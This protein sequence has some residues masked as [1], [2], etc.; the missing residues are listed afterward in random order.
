MGL[1][2]DCCGTCGS[3]LYDHSGIFG[4][5]YLCKCSASPYFDEFTEY[6]DYC[7]EYRERGTQRPV[8]DFDDD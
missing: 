1:F 6:D 3:H 7:D 2:N 4:D 5:C 8:A